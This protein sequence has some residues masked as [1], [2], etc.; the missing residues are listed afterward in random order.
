MYESLEKCEMCHRRKGK[1]RLV[2][3][4]MEQKLCDPCAGEMRAIGETV[5][6]LR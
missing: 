4:N 5:E 1:W 6:T 2:D 3:G